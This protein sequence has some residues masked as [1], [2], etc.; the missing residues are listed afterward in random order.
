MHVVLDFCDIAVATHALSFPGHICFIPAVYRF[1]CCLW[2]YQSS[3][4]E[5]WTSCY[6][7]LRNL[8]CT[9]SRQVCLINDKSLQADCFGCRSEQE[10][11][12]F[13]EILSASF[14][15]IVVVSFE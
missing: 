3:N 5:G 1:N 8:I 7:F 11:V 4:I 14:P 13:Y 15:L 6:I 10:N 2:S 9:S 12:N